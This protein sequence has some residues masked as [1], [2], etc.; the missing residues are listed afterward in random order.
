MEYK[1]EKNQS[2]TNGIKL[3]EGRTEY[4]IWVPMVN[5]VAYF[6]SHTQASTVRKL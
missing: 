2:S 4:N 5:C 3:K 1:K 6:V